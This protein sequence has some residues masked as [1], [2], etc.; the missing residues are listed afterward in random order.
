MAK[1][2]IYPPVEIG[3]EFNHWTVKEKTNRK[4]TW[5]CECKCGTVKTVLIYYLFN[6]K[7]KSCGCARDES[8]S[9]RFKKHGMSSSIEF[10]TWLRM[11]GRTNN[12]NNKK[13]KNYGARGIRVCKYWF[14]SFEAFYRDMG[15]RPGKNYSIE[16][17]DNNA[18]YSCG[19]CEE[20]I[21]NGWS[22]NCRWATN[23]EQ[24]FNKT[25]S[26]FY[27]FDGK[28]MTIAEWAKETGIPYLCIYKRI[29]NGVEPEKVFQ[30]SRS[31]GRNYL[32]SYNGESHN[33]K[34]WSAILGFSSHVIHDRLSDGWTIEEI[35][36]TP[37]QVNYRRMKIKKTV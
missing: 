36:T 17:K 26:V 29:K 14:D 8:T 19:H 37:L 27:T 25:T 21:T 15:S 20:C 4:D 28:T 9:K 6:N 34:E 2:S 16:R 12:P 1:K 22:A 24:A 23:S 31:I 7:S 33:I 13:F 18:N 10:S 32:L 5:L 30:P 35:M 3:Q 11:K